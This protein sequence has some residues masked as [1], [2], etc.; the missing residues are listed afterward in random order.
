MNSRRSFLR[1]VS[2]GAAISTFGSQLRAA[3]SERLNLGFIGVGTMGRYHLGALVGRGDIQVVAVCDVVRERCESAAE[4]VGKA[5][6]G[7]GGRAHADVKM[8][9]DFRDLLADSSVDAVV[10]ATPDHWH[11][12]PCILAARAGKHIYCEK[13]L[14]HHIAEGRRI[15]DEVRQAGVT[16]QTG[17]QQRSEFGGHFRRAVEY[18]HNGRIGKVKVI[19]IGVGGPPKL[20]DLPSQEVPEGTDWNFW[21]GPA[22]ERP[23]HEVLC[24][25]GV[26]S[27]FPQWRSYSEYAGGGLADM[28]AHHFDIA[29]WALGMDASGP[30]QLI[31]PDDPAT[32]RGLKFIYENGVTMFHNEFEPGAEA[33]CV[34]EGS[35]GTILVSRSGI[36]SRPDSI[37]NEPLANDAVRVKPS[38][39]HHADWLD[40]IRSGKDPICTAET[41][42]RSAT[43]CHLANIGYALGRPL[44][45]DPKKESFIDDRQASARLAREARGEWSKV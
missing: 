4:I 1:A 41:G 13:P 14:T 22:P 16:F 10:I 43:I 11:A 29:Q 33:D 31:P 17:S 25:R 30:V 36:S 34:I 15:I 23:Y 45:W 24:P 3:P 39:N 7:K 6:A 2:A 35:E 37:L 44:R 18:V 12:I 20:C 19:R 9:A 5:Y 40:A 42:H 38:S 28:G 32:G 8:H 26:H 27:H 21:Q